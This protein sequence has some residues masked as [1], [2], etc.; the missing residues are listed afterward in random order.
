M[1]P[2]GEPTLGEILAAAF[3]AA[4]PE[5]HPGALEF[6]TGRYLAALT[7]EHLDVDWNDAWDALCSVPDADLGALKI[8]SGWTALAATIANKLG[9]KADP[10]LVWVH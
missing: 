6:E 9:V 7:A 4:P 5:P 1:L 10:L 3:A 2:G 8:A